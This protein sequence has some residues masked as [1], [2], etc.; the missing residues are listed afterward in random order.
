MK[1]DIL[2]SSNIYFIKKLNYFLFY[3]NKII[4]NYKLSM[5][6]NVY[7]SLLLEFIK[8]QHLQ[9]CVFPH[10]IQ[11]N[12]NIILDLIKYDTRYLQYA[13]KELIGYREV[14]L[15][16]VQKYGIALEF[17]SG[18]LRGDIEVVLAAVHSRGEAF[19][20]ASEELKG[21]REV[22]LAVVK[23][24]SIALRYASK[25]LRED[26]E[27]IL[28]VVKQNGWLLKYA[29]Y[30]LR[31]DKEV[32]LAAVQQN[33]DALFYASEKLKA[34]KEVALAAFN[35][36][37]LQLK[38]VSK[39]LQN[40]IEVVLAAVRSHGKALKY[41]SEELRADKL[42]LIECYKINKLTIKYSDFIKQFDKL[43]NGIFYYTFIKKNVDI[44]DLVENKEQL[45]EYLLKNKKYITIYDNEDISNN[46]RDKYKIIILSLDD[47]KPITD[48]NIVTEEKTEEEI[49]KEYENRYI[50]F[51]VIFI[52]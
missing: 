38:N 31:K 34:N 46:I 7:Y 49:K 20:F 8:K 5:I 40:D 13:S 15:V 18:E 22:V 2:V 44:L 48:D 47:I 26:R 4:N 28:A 17:A 35:S 3:Y 43:E 11:N 27:F 36:N 41:A 1:I 42:F 37:G 51:Q 33:G 9:T 32:V 25:Q 29:S 50:G 6:D 14:V 19:E 23:Q 16:A 45:C 21:D 30:E 10:S 24:N 39:E 12:Y 52:L